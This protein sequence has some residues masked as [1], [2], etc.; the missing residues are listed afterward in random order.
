[1][2]RSAVSFSV[3]HSDSSA[4][5]VRFFRSSQEL[6]EGCQRYTWADLKWKPTKTP[7]YKTTH[8]A[9][10]LPQNPFDSQQ[11]L[12]GIHPDRIERGMPHMDTDPFLQQPQ[13]F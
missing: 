5:E 8:L 13:L 6:T 3:S 7:D 9:S 10:P 2:E 11:I 1:V 4:P 12:L